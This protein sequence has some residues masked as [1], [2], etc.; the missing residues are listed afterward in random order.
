MTPQALLVLILGIISAEF[1]FEMVLD[2]LNYVH[3][4]TE[5]PSALRD[6]YDPEQ[7][8]QSLA[9]HRANARFGFLSDSFSFLLSFLL[10]ALGGFGWLHQVVSQWWIAPIPQS[11][12]FFALVFVLSDG[13][14]LPFQLYRTFVVEER[15]GF[16]KTTVRT[17]FLDKLKS[18]GIG[19]VLGAP[20]LGLFVWLMLSLG[21]G[22][23]VY[24]WVAISAFMVFISLFYT[25]LI[26]PLFNK[27]SP[28]PEGELRQAIEEFARQVRFPMANVYVI[29][30]S[31]RSAKAN[32]FFS[33]LGARKK[34][35]LYDTLISSCTTEQLVA[36]LAHE[37]GHYKRNHMVRSMTLSVLQSGVM[38]YLLSFFVFSPALSQAL[39]SP[40]WAI[41]L[42]LIAFGI[43]YGPVSKI[44]GLGMNILSRRQEFEA[45]AFAAAAYGAQHLSEALKKLSVNNLSHLT[46]HP[47]YVYYHY[48][49]PPLAQRL[50]ALQRQEIKFT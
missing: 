38:L 20:L 46:P 43:L 18:Y 33:G 42:N 6:V 26:L 39:G 15:F 34:I 12:A 22:F 5:P 28:L 3:H 41:P 17:F 27:L 29:D 37:V 25:T 14:S 11:L 35:V 47:A 9:Y 10:L 36:V 2:Y 24:F 13:I 45:D 48:S 32:A 4:P 30:G 16:N 40:E 19:A 50:S 31:K 21:A 7:Y 49:H 1:I 8:R 44:I 23:W